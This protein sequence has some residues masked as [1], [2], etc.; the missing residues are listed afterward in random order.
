MSKH[1]HVLH[2]IFQDPISANMH[3]REVE[4][5]LNHLGATVKPTHGAR[6]H[7]TLN[8]IEIIL[9]HPHQSSEC[10]RQDIKQIREFLIQAGIQPESD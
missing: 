10:T 9:H 3:W 5:L 2:T 7:V 1:K 8:K 4:S 6:F